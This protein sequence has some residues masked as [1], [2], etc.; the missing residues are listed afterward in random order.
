MVSERRSTADDKR[1]NGMSW[2]NV[3]SQNLPGEY[4]PSFP[5]SRNFYNHLSFFKRL[6]STAKDSHYLLILQ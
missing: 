4:P 1:Q 2:I 6:S 5:N 3:C